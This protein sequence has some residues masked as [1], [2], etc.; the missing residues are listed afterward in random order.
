MKLAHIDI[1]RLFILLLLVTVAVAIAS[2]TIGKD[3]YYNDEM[4]ML[5]FA[6]VN[7]SGYLFFLFMP[8]EL[9]FIFYMKSGYDPWTL[10][11]VAIGTAVLSQSIDYLIGYFFSSG[12]ID[13]LIGRNRYEMAESEIRKYGNLTLLVFNLLPLSSPA[14]ALAAGM[15]KYRIKDALLYSL[16]GLTL[17]YLLLT[18]IF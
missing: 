9:A 14:I 5:S 3:I 10:N 17:K 13:R 1:K 16:A 4:S 2:L 7:F 11:L 6:I 8:V 15:L 18:L 12:I